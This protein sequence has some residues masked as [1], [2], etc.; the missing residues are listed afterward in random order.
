[1]TVRSTLFLVQCAS[2][3]RSSAMPARDLYC[4]PWFVKAR[5][6]VEHQGGRW[7]ILSAKHHVVEPHQVLKPYDVTLN[8]MSAVRRRQW[9]EQ[10]LV[11][12]RRRCRAGHRVVILAG[13]AYRRHLVPALA[14]WGCRVEVPMEGLGIG[15]QLR[16]LDEQ[17]MR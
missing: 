17:T 3:K 5:A 9:A 10:V 15:K 13:D 6:Y 2:K 14:Q 8:R 1:M 4:S 12:L 11:A 7:L 16:W